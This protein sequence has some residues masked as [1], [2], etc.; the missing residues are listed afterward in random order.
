MVWYGMVW[1]GILRIYQAQ[2]YILH[3]PVSCSAKC[4]AFLLQSCPFLSF[5][6]I[7]PISYFDIK[8]LVLQLLLRMH[9]S[10]SLSTSLSLT[11]PGIES[12][13]CTSMI[14]IV[15]F[16]F[17]FTL[18]YCIAL[19]AQT[20][21]DMPVHAYSMYVYITNCTMSHTHV[22]TYTCMYVCRLPRGQSAIATC[23]AILLHLFLPCKCWEKMS[24]KGLQTF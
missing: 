15:I 10:L 2:F 22:H 11:Y 19:Q 16:D 13:G 21:T 24:L 9:L 14:S 6:V 17:D 3:S 1:Y 8:L 20:C 7:F 18:F 4:A 12:G 5:G 23:P